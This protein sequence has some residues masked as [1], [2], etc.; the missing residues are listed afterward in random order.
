MN[1]LNIAAVSICLVATVFAIPSHA[2]G[3]PITYSWV[4]R[5]V[6][7]KVEQ[8]PWNLGSQ[9][10]PFFISATVDDM[11]LDVDPEVDG[12]FF[13][14][15]EIVFLID[16]EAPTSLGNEFGTG[17]I[18]FQDFASR[19]DITIL[20]NDVRFNGVT[21][22]GLITGVR[23]PVSTFNLTNIVE[24]PP[25]FSPT[26]TISGVV[27]RGVG[28]SYVTITEGGV[29]V[30]IPEPSTFVLALLALSVLGTRLFWRNVVV[31]R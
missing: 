20:L 3:A 10:R 23:L 21:E 27:A 4:G 15:P 29:L 16:G 12:A 11:A 30:P 26:P 13:E 14:S 6:P 2:M 25:R 31:A 1:R 5:I 9:G 18:W 8:D 19:D 24:A 17:G 28:S 7:E 22:E